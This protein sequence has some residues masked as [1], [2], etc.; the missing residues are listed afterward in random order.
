VLVVAPTRELVLQTA[1]V[2]SGFARP[3]RRRIKIVAAYGGGSVNPQMMALRGGADIV[4]ATPGRLL[5]LHRRGAVEFTTLQT[6]VLDEG[7][8]LLGPEFMDELV[9]VVSRLPARR[10][11]LL[12]SATFSPQVRDLARVLLR[13]PLEI[14][15]ADATATQPGETSAPAPPEPSIEQHVYSVAPERKTALLIHLLR[16]RELGQ[17]LVF[18]SA[19]K[20]GDKL[21]LKLNQAEIQAAVFHAEKSQYERI[22]RLEAFRTGKLRVLI[23]TDLAARGIDIEELPA[24]INFELPRSPNDYI[25]RIGRT[26]RAGRTGLAISLISAE[27]EERHFRVIEK[28][29]RRRLPRESVTGFEPR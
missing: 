20:T 23:A 27:Q 21:V 28:R 12:F 11:N 29:I 1:D 8:R 26:G 7:D 17:A 9:Q 25:H 10:Q 14:G 6:L 4:V 3:L 19:R 2:L 15:L 24:V 18:V 5:D 13:D 16:Q 22:Q